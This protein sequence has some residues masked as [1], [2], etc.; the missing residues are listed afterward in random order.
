CAS[1]VLRSAGSTCS[2]RIRSKRGSPVSARS[3][4][5]VIGSADAVIAKR[6]RRLVRVVRRG[7]RPAIM[8]SRVPERTAGGASGPVACAVPLDLPVPGALRARLSAPRRERGPAVKSFDLIVLGGGSGGLAT[9]QRAADHGA[10][11]VLFEP[12]RLGGTCVNVGCVPKKVIWNAAELAHA[13]AHA[14]DYGFDVDASAVRHDWGKLKRG[15]DAYVE[16]LNGIYARNLARREID[17][18][19][20]RARFVG[21]REVADEE[22]NRYKAAHVLIATGGYPLV[23]ELPGAELG[24]TSD[25]FFELESRPQRVALVGSGYVS[26]ELG[27]VLRSLGSDVTIFMRFDRLVRYFDTLIGDHLMQHMRDAG[28]ELVTGAMPRAL[29]AASEGSGPLTLEL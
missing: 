4:L 17:V 7:G 22:G 6:P 8:Q 18:V 25:G 1:S 12:A 19:A 9:A 21:P 24:I 28:I 10:S 20:Q 2:G 15:R 11:V 27:G 5:S 13:I 29:K 23:P 3:G 26:V 14:G 16:R